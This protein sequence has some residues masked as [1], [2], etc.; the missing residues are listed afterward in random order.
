MTWNNRHNTNHNWWWF[1]CRWRGLWRKVWRFIPRLRFFFLKVEFS[2]RT[3]IPLFFLKARIIPQWFIELRRRRPCVPGRVACELASLIGSQTTAWTEESAP[4]NFVESRVHA[5]LT[6]TFQPAE[7]PESF[8]CQCDKTW[9]KRTP[10]KSQHWKLTLAKK[11]LPRL[12][13]GFDSTTTW[14]RVWI[15]TRWAIPTPFLLLINKTA[16]TTVFFKTV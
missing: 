14:S 6:V 2:S 16:K 11:I 4:S 15:S 13:P 1:F 9:M 12:L 7:W 3:P 8:T 10:N 5:Y